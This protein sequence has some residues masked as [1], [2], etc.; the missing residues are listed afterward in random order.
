MGI[1]FKP[2][3]PKCQA[4]E[5]C[6]DE[7]GNIDPEELVRQAKDKSHALHG[8]IYK[9]KD[10][11]AAHEY[12]VGVARDIIRVYRLTV[13]H[14]VFKLSAPVYIGNPDVP[15]KYT[16]AAKVATDKDQ[17]KR[18]LQIELERIKGAIKR[19]LTLSAT[20]DM[21][22]DF[23]MMLDAAIRIEKSHVGL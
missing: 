18:V 8:D 15:G 20:F 17:S 4:I 16:K 14:E 12:R 7:D 23:E 5:A 6:M 13:Y 10:S 22:R 21:K 2:G 9:L 11:E 3:D 1:E 19:A